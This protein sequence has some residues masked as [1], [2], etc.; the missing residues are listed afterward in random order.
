MS[1]ILMQSVV[2]S[3]FT[4]IE[5]SLNSVALILWVYW[6]PSLLFQREMHDHTKNLTIEKLQIIIW[7]FKDLNV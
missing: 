5:Q 3:I 6:I 4:L 1:Q 2:A 7:L